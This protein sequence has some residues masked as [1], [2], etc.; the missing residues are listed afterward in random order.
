MGL[1]RAAFAGEVSP[2][3]PRDL[4]VR[5]DAPT[6][7]FGFPADTRLPALRVREWRRAGVEDKE[8]LNQFASGLMLDAAKARRGDSS[9]AGNDAQGT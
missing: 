8:P 7:P 2:F 4:D 5:D 3:D 6:W 9:A 1:G